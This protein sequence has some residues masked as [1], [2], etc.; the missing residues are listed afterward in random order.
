ME[1][2]NLK[3]K[4]LLDS[5]DLIKRIADSMII[6]IHNSISIADL[7][8]YVRQALLIYS[9]AIDE[10]PFY[11]IKDI[12]IED[13]TLGFN[14]V[15]FEVLI[16][17]FGEYK[18]YIFSLVDALRKVLSIVCN[19]SYFKYVNAGT[20][21]IL[22]SDLDIDP[23]YDELLP[24]PL[25]WLGQ[26]PE[27]RKLTFIYRNR[28]FSI[29]ADWEFDLAYDLIISTDSKDL[30]KDFYRTDYSDFLL[31][32]YMFEND[33]LPWSVESFKRYLER[34]HCIGGAHHLKCFVKLLKS[35]K[36]VTQEEVNKFERKAQ[37]TRVYRRLL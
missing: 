5:A 24:L 9:K 12:T 7:D 17:D 28:E 18:S 4:Y 13:Y 35:F 37:I 27:E 14:A 11:S 33:V 25:E 6:N 23:F 32:E 15:I 2:T 34:F 16:T 26:K 22:D 20:P 10:T 21:I 31:S 8:I 29:S 1:L 19:D 30:Y 36:K 3:R